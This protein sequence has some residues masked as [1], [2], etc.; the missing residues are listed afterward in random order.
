[1]I[2]VIFKI[3][4]FESEYDISYVLWDRIIPLGHQIKEKKI[5]VQEWTIQGS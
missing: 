5:G 1:M 3:A 2:V 4:D